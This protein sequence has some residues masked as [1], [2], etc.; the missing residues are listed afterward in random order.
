MPTNWETGGLLPAS[1]ANRVLSAAIAESVVMRLA[2]IERM[3]EHIESVPVISVAPTAC[4]PQR[5]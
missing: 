2:T 4:V 5:R 3:E 1:V